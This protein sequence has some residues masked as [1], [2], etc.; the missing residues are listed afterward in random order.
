[1]NSFVPDN[2][3]SCDTMVSVGETSAR[4]NTVFGKN[5]DR[6]AEETQPLELHLR[7]E[8][9]AGT[10]AGCQFVN[11]PQV[12]TTYRHV[13]SRPYWCH[14]YEHGFTA[15]YALSD[16]ASCRGMAHSTDLRERI[17]N[18]VIHK[19]YTLQKA[20]DTFDVG[21]ATVS[22]YL[23]RYRQTGDLTPRTSPGRPSALNEYQAWV[24]Q[25]PHQQRPHPRP[26][27][28]PAVRRNWRPHQQSHQVPL[29]TEIGIDEKKRRSTPVNRVQRPGGGTWPG[30]SRSTR[31][32]RCSWMRA[33]STSP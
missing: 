27:L 14:G 1:M 10:E 9:P 31:T 6:P 21:A 32:G 28:R 4:S 17:I 8:H 30:S 11:V 2:V 26:A 5:S 23:R 33:A 7:Q 24:E 15:G 16:R 20:A 3:G 13:G 22:R 29:G 12:P 25:K 19:R 18:A